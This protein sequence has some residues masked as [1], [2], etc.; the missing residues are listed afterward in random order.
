MES[1]RVVPLGLN[2]TT[3]MIRGKNLDEKT[4]SLLQRRL[5]DLNRQMQSEQEEKQR[6]E[7]EIKKP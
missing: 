5:N 7:E 6:L 3:N 1:Y 2:F 4:Q